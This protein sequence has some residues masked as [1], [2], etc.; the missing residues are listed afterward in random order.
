MSLSSRAVALAAVTGCPRLRVAARRGFGDTTVAKTKGIDSLTPRLA[1]EEGQRFEERA[2]GSIRKPN[3][4]DLLAL[5][6]VG[7]GKV[8]RFPDKVAEDDMLDEFDAAVADPTVAVIVQG[9][10]PGL[11]GGY[12]RPDLLIR[13]EQGWDVGEVKVYLDKGGDTSPRLIQS[14]AAQVAVSIVAAR[15]HGMNVSD[16]G[17]VI[18]ASQRGTPSVRPMLLGGEIEL[19]ESLLEVAPLTPSEAR[20]GLPESLG[21][22]IYSPAC[23]GKCA[24]ADF[25]RDEA[26]R[27]PGVLW[28]G[29]TVA[30]TYGWSHVDLLAMCAEGRGPDAVQA[31]W[32]AASA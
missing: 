7:D 28:S 21:E 18:L 27:A 10:L 19:V 11:Y 5:L 26:Q 25:C 13:T 12:H 20:Q 22:H 16:R 32:E 31:G 23:E 6:G 4:E 14:T 2:I 3:D 24:L 1:F 29:D 17:I 9:V 8:V 15:R 30:P